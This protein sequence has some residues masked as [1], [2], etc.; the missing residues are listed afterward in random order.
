MNSIE[1]TEEV[2]EDLIKVVPEIES[3]PDI[4][5]HL[6]LPEDEDLTRQIATFTK[7]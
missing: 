1:L 5:T 3:C 2:L 4:P 7:Q 6:I